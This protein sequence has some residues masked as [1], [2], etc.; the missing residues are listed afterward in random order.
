LVKK[1]LF[2]LALL[3]CPLLSAQSGDPE[4]IGEY[5]VT[6]EQV[7]SRHDIRLIATNRG[8][9]AVTLFMNISGDNFL[10]DKELPLAAVIAPESEQEIVRISPRDHWEPV[11]FTYTHV[12]NL[13]DAFMPP[14]K[15]YP[16]RLPFP[17]G[18]Q[19]KVVQEPNGIL[20]THDAIYTR[21][22]IDFAVPQG[23]PVTA[24]RT[25]I[26][27]D[28][29]DQFTEGRPDQTL[30]DSANFVAV[31][32]SDHSIAYYLHLAPNGV[33]VQPG[34]QV[35]AGDLI[36]YS[37]N[38]GFTHGPHLHFD[39]RRAIIRP[40]GDVV[41]ESIPVDFYSRNTRNKITLKEDLQITAD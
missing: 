11:H 5:P 38:T 12:F 13:G 9:A 10:S 39:V 31:M 19:A 14:D 23:T 16:Y 36:A 25:G 1:L 2:L 18:T 26:V 28:M 32:H 22:A 41:Q 27:I 15:D 3:Y 8:S 35:L 17:S 21:Y 24:A 33:L 6:I 34:Q 37:G 29:R 30:I 20:R 40:G 4:D 7:N